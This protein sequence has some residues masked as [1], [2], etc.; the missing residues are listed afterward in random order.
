MTPFAALIHLTQRTY[1]PVEGSVMS[2]EKAPPLPNV[3]IQ[4]FDAI[5]ADG[6]PVQYQP[7]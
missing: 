1:A 5:N 4:T 3:T 2:F 7:A 6:V